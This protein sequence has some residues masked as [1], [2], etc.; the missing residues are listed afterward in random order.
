MS[1]RSLVLDQDA[2]S[3]LRRVVARGNSVM[4]DEVRIALARNAVDSRLSTVLYVAVMAGVP[5][6]LRTASA[7]AN[8]SGM[9]EVVS[10]SATRLA[11]EYSLKAQ[12]CWNAVC[13]WALV[14]DLVDGATIASW[15]PPLEPVHAVPAPI[16]HLGPLSVE[17]TGLTDLIA[18]LRSQHDH[19]T[20]LATQ[21]RELAG[22]VTT[23]TGSVTAV[24][25]DRLIHSESEGTS[26]PGSAPQGSADE[27]DAVEQAE[28]ITRLREEARKVEEARRE[29]Q[30]V[31]N[32]SRKSSEALRIIE[33]G[34]RALILRTSTDASSGASDEIPLAEWRTRIWGL[35]SA[36]ATLKH[37]GEPTD[38]FERPISEYL[39]AFTTK[40]LDAP[41]WDQFDYLSGE[42]AR[43]LGWEL[44]ATT[45]VRQALETRMQ[46]LVTAEERAVRPQLTPV[47]PAEGPKAV[48]TR[49]LALQRRRGHLQQ[50]RSTLAG[51][52]SVV[53]K[54][55]DQTIKFAATRLAEVEQAIT[56]ATGHRKRQQ[57]LWERWTSASTDPAVQDAVLEEAD[58][59]G[60]A[61]FD[62]PDQTPGTVL[63]ERA[64]SRQ[65]APMSLEFGVDAVS[66]KARAHASQRLRGYWPLRASADTL[67]DD[68]KGIAV[69]VAA[70]GKVVLV[71]ELR[72][73]ANDSARLRTVKTALS[74]LEILVEKSKNGN[75]NPWTG[76]LDHTER[77][78]GAYWFLAYHPVVRKSITELLKTGLVH[79][80][81]WGRQWLQDW[82]GT[83]EERMKRVLTDLSRL[84]SVADDPE[85]ESGSVKKLQGEWDNVLRLRHGL[86]SEC[87]DLFDRVV[88]NSDNWNTIRSAE[89][90]IATLSKKCATDYSRDLEARLTVILGTTNR[91]AA[92]TLVTES[93]V[94]ATMSRATPLTGKEKAD[95]YRAYVE[96]IRQFARDHLARIKTNTRVSD[97]TRRAWEWLR[98]NPEEEWLAQY[99]KRVLELKGNF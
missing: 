47:G 59:D 91:L 50:L 5:T 25:Q 69:R 22:A 45:S 98:D 72:D 92:P 77:V 36:I 1:E 46:Q 35:A 83:A 32:N 56:A 33:A 61:F 28:R 78:T 80:L 87:Q 94:S 41:A 63:Q 54:K 60:V 10:Q 65:E 55:R 62:D 34:L 79:G 97:G 86:E 19:Q 42:M 18:E 64:N 27:L 81:G 96:E 8:G 39:S 13:T 20:L 21:M 14:L 26:G 23:L 16:A 52:P 58:R 4:P 73:L 29:L 17:V 2:V 40:P 82:T 75:V 24:L 85:A 6:S 76:A 90:E 89:R 11:D 49:L 84:A 30:S 48:A 88:T 71:G 70:S 9:A 12:P 38:Q 37:L 7:R 31:E 95:R 99:A 15:A 51:A 53:A 66:A 68:L 74:S 93:L 44:P 67:Q 43:A 3:A 57:A